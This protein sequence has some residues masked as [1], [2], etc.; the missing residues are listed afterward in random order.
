[1]RPRC[2]DCGT[3]AGIVWFVDVPTGERRCGP[4]HV[5]SMPL[6]VRGERPARC[7][8]CGLIVEK[9]VGIHVKTRKVWFC[10]GEATC[11]LDERRSKRLERN[12]Q[13][14]CVAGIGTRSP[15]GLAPIG[16][17]PSITAAESLTRTG[18]PS[19]SRTSPV[20]SSAGKF[21]YALAQRALFREGLD[22][23]EDPAPEEVEEGWSVE[24]VSMYGREPAG[25]RIVKRE[26]SKWKVIKIRKQT[27]VEEIEFDPLAS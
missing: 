27:P 20:P 24:A 23:A 22:F 15:R 9:D 8:W 13:N 16:L 6:A 21:E 12:S 17:P 5:G 3:D 1:M 19:V 10:G 11:Q 14:A 4:C 18:N 7:H 2:L 26:G 25:R